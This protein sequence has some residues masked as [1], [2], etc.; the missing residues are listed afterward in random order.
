MALKQHQSHG[1]RP[2]ASAEQIRAEM[3]A[4]ELKR[5]T[6]SMPLADEKKLL[7]DLENLKTQLAQTEANDEFQKMLDS[8][9]A[10]RAT[11][12]QQHREME[13]QLAELLAAAKKLSLA[14]K[15]GV[16]SADF[17]TIEV[18]VPD[19][20]MGA[21][22][23][24]QFA[25][26]R[27][28]ERTY[29]AILDVREESK[30]ASDGKKAIKVTS[31]RANVKSAKRA[32]ENIALASSHS[33]GLH[34]DAV[35]LLLFQQ[36][37]KLQELQE[38]LSVN[39]LDISKADG[40]LTVFASP[41]VV[42]ELEQEIK[43]LTARTISIPLPQEVVPKLIGKKGETITQLMQDT[44]A[45]VDI[46]RVV[47]SVRIC[48]TIDSVERAD[49]FVRDLIDEQERREKTF[50]PA[51]KDFFGWTSADPIDAVADAERRDAMFAFF[52]EFLMINKAAQLQ[53]LRR[54][55]GDARIKVAKKERSIIMSGTK[56]QLVAAEDALRAS[57]KVF[58]DSHWVCEVR[59]HHLLSLIIGKKGATIKEIEGGSAKSTKKEEKRDDEAGE[60]ADKNEKAGS[61]RIDIEDPFV[62]VLGDSE[63]A[64]E[65]ARS[66]ISSIIDKNQRAFFSTSPHL[67]PVLAGSKRAKVNE[68]EKATGGECKV[69]L[70]SLFTGRGGNNTGASRNTAA[71]SATTDRV[72]ISLTG[73]LAGIQEAKR[74]LQLL[75]DSNHVRYMPLDADEVPTV[76]GKK[77]ET[78]AKLEAES[79]AKLKVLRGSDL[80]SQHDMG[81]DGASTS[82]AELEMIGTNEQLDA[83]QRA[84]D[85]L[86]QTSNRRLLQLDAF[87]TGCLIG[88]KG[89]R[90]RTLRAD[91]PDAMIDAFPARG[92]IRIKASSPEKLQECVDHVLRELRETSVVET[93]KMPAAAS[94]AASSNSG[95]VLNFNTVFKQNPA[96][97]MRLQELE[98]EGGEGMKVAIQD[99]GKTARIRGPAMGVGALKK[100]LEMLVAVMM[101]SNAPSN[102]TGADSTSALFVETIPLPSFSFASA[103]VDKSGAL[104]ENATRICKQTG[105]E[106]RV[107]RQQGGSANSSTLTTNDLVADG[108]IH[109]EGTR[110]ASV[111]DAKARVEN[112]LQFYYSECMAVID[113][114][115]ALAVPRL[116]EM[117]P[118]LREAKDEKTRKSKGQRRVFFSLPSATSLRIL[119]DAE[120]TTQQVAKRVRDELA[121]WKK[122]HVV[123]PVESWLVPILVGKNGETIQ[124]LST[125]SNGARLDLSAAPGGKGNGHNHNGNK[126]RTLTISAR[127][128]ASVK[129]AV[130]NVKKLLTHHRNRA[131]IV[132]VPAAKLD[133]ALASVRKETGKG[134]NVQLH[135]VDVDENTRQVV[136]YSDKDDEERERLHEKLEHVISTSVVETLTL[137]GAASIPGSSVGTA[138]IGALIGKAGANIKALQH[139]FSDVVIDIQRDGAPV[140]SL[141][142]PRDDVERVKHVVDDKI[143]EL[144]AKEEALQEQR[145]QRYGAREEE[146]AAKEP[147]QAREKKPKASESDAA[148]GDENARPNNANTWTIGRVPV[149]ATPG[150]AGAGAVKLT[151][152]Q[153]RRMRKRAE[154]EKQDNNVLSMLVGGDDGVASSDV[155]TTTTTVTT[156]VGA[157]G[158]TMTTTK[159]TKTTKTAATGGGESGGYYHSSSGYSL[160]L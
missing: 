23:G 96:I 148:P 20:R 34:P 87:A 154:N 64:I 138:V 11:R 89:E 3:A 32:I 50:T 7:R 66:N 79:G 41:S 152:N 82:A 125:E 151:K 54:E 140:I 106:L 90:I 26:L 113:G 28:L 86:L 155:T 67:I 157:N 145:R 110:A 104:N 144:V 2:A 122:R 51:D 59:D 12:F 63:A 4:K 16:S 29:L 5:S 111:Y 91:H 136:L 116:Y 48:G 153:R 27:Q 126:P 74:Q 93:V 44:G 101:V 147:E 6:T 131:A 100:F 103:L 128:D 159:V 35:K 56:A 49:D 31:A 24:K 65:R 19:D 25:N 36:A 160:R 47:N 75:E 158:A 105:C 45:L 69:F 97:A 46:D 21:V 42:T 117:L 124:K 43:K 84:L 102:S 94:T 60:E 73:T 58:N 76:I 141:K 14:V 118:T 112:V 55:A 1:R 114:L 123:L 38:K 119:T 146:E 13:A 71:A 134:T 52:C 40:V 98:A 130:E 108:V 95:V 62:C 81:S 150:L 121:H 109:I 57:V 139:K 129:L 83:V 107:T 99:D 115:P 80:E 142:G 68:I 30:E 156:A 137:P 120:S 78:V 135:V 37:K 39:R 18:P 70:P 127:D 133:L 15:L 17:V 72:K 33:I 77:G 8:T 88:K 132:D 61:V 10:E 149:G 85:E 92:H 143:Q 22:L 9:R 53:T